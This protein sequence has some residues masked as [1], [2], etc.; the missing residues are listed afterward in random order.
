MIAILQVTSDITRHPDSIPDS[1]SV[2]PIVPD[3][4]SGT[5]GNSRVI[6]VFIGES[7]VTPQGTPIETPI[8]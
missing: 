4:L 5:I 6:S 8:R 3:E 2:I 7:S 1:V